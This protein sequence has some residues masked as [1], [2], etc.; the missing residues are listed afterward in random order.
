MAKMPLYF[1]AAIFVAVFYFVWH[2]RR[3]S[4]INATFAAFTITLCLW[5]LSIALVQ[6][7][8][9]VEPWVR[10]SFAA[11]SLIPSAF[12]AFV[13]VYPTVTAW[14][15]RA[16][17]ICAAVT[18][19]GFSI[20][21]LSTRAV[22]HDA[23]RIDGVLVRTPGSLYP[24][25]A[26]YFL[27][28]WTAA[29]AII[30]LKWRK[31]RGLTRAQ[32]NYLTVGIFIFGIGGMTTNL[33]LPLLTG[34]STYIWAG[35]CFAL[36]FLLF[37][38]HAIAR[39][40]LLDIRL[41]LLRGLAIAIATVVSLVLVAIFFSVF[42]FNVLTHLEPSELVLVLAA[43]A[44][45]CLV[46]SLIRDFAGQRLDR[47]VYRT[48][49]S[50][51]KTLK[52]ASKVL[53]GVLDLKVLIPFV[54]RTIRMSLQP[55]TVII[56]INHFDGDQALLKAHAEHCLSNSSVLVPDQLPRGLL[57]ELRGVNDILV[58]DGRQ[59]KTG[60]FAAEIIEAATSLNCELLVPLIFEDAVIGAIVV[61]PKLSGDP[62]Y[63]Q[64]LDL[65]M[66]L[67]NQAGIAVKNAQLYGQVVLA[68]EYLENIVS[69][70]DSGVVAVNASGHV[71]MFNRAA[72]TL[73]GREPAS[74]RGAHV[75]VLPACLG[76]TLRAT[77]VERVKQMLPEIPLSDGTVTRPVICATSPVR[78]PSGTSVGAVAVFS[79]L[80]PL[81]ELERQRRRAERLAYFEALA[82]AIAHEIKNPLVA[83]KTFAQL[84]P[85]RRDNET[86]LENFGR[87]V[88]RE[89]GRMER[90][91]ER[92]RTLSRPGSRPR[93]P[94]DV[95]VPM[96]ESLELLQP[97]FE[98]KRIGVSV[99]LGE[100]SHLVVGD[101]GELGELFLNLLM[102]AQE[103]TPPDGR[104]TVELSATTTHV[105]ITLIDSGP[106]IPEAL[107]ER[108]FE[109]FVTTKQTGSGLGLAI[110]MGI[111]EAHDAKLRV[112]N[113]PIGGARFDV[114][115]PIAILVAVGVST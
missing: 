19:A 3:T 70:I 43:M 2:A 54:A 55:E 78:D 48:R 106:G 28:T 5:T 7:A 105:T 61:G 111:A 32:L 31:S 17:V 107:L 102:N 42:A 46:V 60:K 86:F 101:D 69:T 71:T 41:T 115:F 50:Y 89:I 72:E 95:R 36:A 51:Q 16:L 37:M 6:K 21:S 34:R 74:V 30:G 64:D 56:Y 68:N 33:I 39:H 20:L 14:P 49:V 94:L 44:I 80:T 83:I 84:V 88:T 112:T 8:T 35:P 27:L 114:E 53:T 4:R 99:S 1:V 45:A 75:S 92:L 82:A 11:A 15:T 47:Y 93:H 113:L 108:I 87:V 26:V 24:L 65:L 109:P 85:R 98:E 96:I 40:S 76:E 104:L 100:E 77:M 67:A 9:D 79:D 66:T 90:L 73:T 97:S 91:V 25:F 23:S 59:S 38:G 12:L 110:C 62:F 103:A 52:D 29:L 81:K 58:F 63:P 10:L 13:R 22:I 18:A 57:N